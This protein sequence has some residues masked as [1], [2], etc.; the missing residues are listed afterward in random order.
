MDGQIEIVNRTLS[1]LLHVVLEKNLRTWEDSLPHVEFT[2]NRVMHTS[3]GY[4]PFE[5]VYGFNP[6]TPLDLL[7]L[8]VE[9]RTSLDGLR[10]NPSQK[11]RN[12][13]GI[14]EVSSHFRSIEPSK[15]F[16]THSDWANL[17]NKAKKIQQT[18][19]GLVE[20]L[21]TKTRSLKDDWMLE[22]ANREVKLIQAQAYA[23]IDFEQPNF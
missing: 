22:R 14:I 17:R 12:D 7:L 4:S 3:T 13:R 1:Q 18:L 10:I 8:P 15:R 16:A 21:K 11:R 9:E 20:G 2:Y 19:V 23:Q 6:L 5:V